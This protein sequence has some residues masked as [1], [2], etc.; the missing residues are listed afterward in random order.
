VPANPTA[1]KGPAARRAE[2]AGPAPTAEVLQTLTRWGLLLKQDKQLPSVV[3]ILTGEPLA[4]S[5]WSHPQSRLIFRVLSELADHPDVLL[6]KL[7]LTKD[8]LVHRNLWPALLAVATAREPWQTARLSAAARGLL[9]RAEKASSPVRASG[10]PVK[11]LASRLL[12]QVVEMHSERGQHE[13]AVT[14]WSRWAEGI[15]VVPMSSLAQARQELEAA[16]QSLGAPPGALPWQA[17]KTR[18]TRGGR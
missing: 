12:V 3:T 2:P 16:A 18:A 14:S 17:R 9:T 15:G 8:T 5:W 13:S 11:E 4:T 1:R 6:S 7:L 10:A